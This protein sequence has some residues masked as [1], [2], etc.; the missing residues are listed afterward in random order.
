M[1]GRELKKLIYSTGMNINQFAKH[2]GI[3]PSTLS[4]TLQRK[5]VGPKWKVN[6]YLYAIFN[7]KLEK[8]TVQEIASRWRG[9]LEKLAEE[10]GTNDFRLY[11]IM[12]GHEKL[13]I[14][15]MY[16]F[17]YAITKAEGVCYDY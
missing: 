11:K 4:K 1:T 2:M 10:S 7:K 17:L 15:R 12:N 16:S 14:F 13:S 5:K 3:D 9:P 8:V 6:S